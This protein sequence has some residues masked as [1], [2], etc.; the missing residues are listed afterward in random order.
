ML[1]KDEKHKVLYVHIVFCIVIVL[2]NS[3]KKQTQASAWVKSS[4]VMPQLPLY[5]SFLLGK[6][7]KLL[8]LKP[9]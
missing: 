4:K 5:L 2:I 3:K 9:Y 8:C 7:G 6:G 1:A